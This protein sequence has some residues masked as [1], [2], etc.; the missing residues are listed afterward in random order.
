MRQ[1]SQPPIALGPSIGRLSAAGLPGVGVG[2]GVDPRA[3]ALASGSPAMSASGS[4]G[5]GLSGLANSNSS[6]S[7]GAGAGVAQM[8][9]AAAAST[10][11]SSNAGASA[12]AIPLPPLPPGA[13]VS[14]A[15][16]RLT[17]V[18][19]DAVAPL[20]ADEV[21]AV[22]GWMA[23]DAAYEGAFR[24]MEDRMRGEAREVR[25]AG[26]AGGGRFWWEVSDRRGRG[27]KFGVVYPGQQQ[28]QQQMQQMQMQQQQMLAMQHGKR[29]KRRE[30]LKLWVARS[31]VFCAC[32]GVLLTVAF[33]SFSWVRFVVLDDGGGGARTVGPAKSGRRTRTGPSSSCRYGLSL[34]SSIIR[35]GTRSCGI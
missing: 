5:G 31:F 25:R 12:G 9:A 24:A 29:R 26:P 2:M 3:S 30:G 20:R 32:V 23:R 13:R 35:C 15:N 16:T 11:H 1:A 33:F 18:A 21:R 28:Q 10:A 7:S 14:K 8:A 27:G 4:G 17:L 34:T 22:E 6:S 19:P